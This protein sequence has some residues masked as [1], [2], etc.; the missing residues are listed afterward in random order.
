MSQIKRV[1]CVLSLCWETENYLFSWF[2]TQK[3][4]R[5]YY[6]VAC[7]TKW[8]EGWSHHLILSPA[9]I[10]ERTK[11]G[12]SNAEESRERKTD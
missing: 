4:A 8:A 11:K 10:E 1:A 12:E 3:D 5:S 6:R 9:G 7:E 2:D